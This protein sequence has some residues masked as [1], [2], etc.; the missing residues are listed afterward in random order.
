MSDTASFCPTLF[1]S[2]YEVA[3]RLDCRPS[4]NVITHFKHHPS[5]TLVLPSVNRESHLEM[6]TTGPSLQ[7]ENIPMPYLVSFLFISL[8][9]IYSQN[10]DDHTFKSF[11][12]LS[13]ICITVE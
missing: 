9:L 6:Y 13:V 5:L 12:K 1:H 8:D 3:E 7:N 4:S 10:F 11:L 2:F